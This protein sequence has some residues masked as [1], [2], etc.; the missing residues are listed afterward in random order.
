MWSREVEKSSSF[1]GFVYTPEAVRGLCSL[2][3]WSH[4]INSIKPKPA[5]TQQWKCCHYMNWG[6][7]VSASSQKP[8]FNANCWLQKNCICTV[9]G[10]LLKL[11]PPLCGLCINPLF[12][13]QTFFF[14]STRNGWDP[15][16]KNGF[17][18]NQLKHCGWCLNCLGSWTVR[19][20]VV[21]GEIQ[22]YRDPSG[23]KGEVTA[24]NTRLETEL[25]Y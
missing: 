19:Q 16:S 20:T 22:R 7:S 18:G 9:D 11:R 8:Y 3:H 5:I 14:L 25:Q 23:D 12:Q 21:L 24:E 15:R 13:I 2:L 10:V 17:L 1:C 6:F 4:S